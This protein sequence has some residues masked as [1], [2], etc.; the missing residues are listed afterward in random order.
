MKKKSAAL[1]LR[2]NKEWDG[3][4]LSPPPPFNLPVLASKHPPKSSALCP[5]PP[6]KQPHR[7]LL[8][9][10]LQGRLQLQ[11]STEV[12]SPVPLSTAEAAAS[13]P[14]RTIPARPPATA[15][16]VVPASHV[17][18]QPP[19]SVS[20]ASPSVLQAAIAREVVISLSDCPCSSHRLPFL[21]LH[22]AAAPSHPS[23]HPLLKLSGRKWNLRLGFFEFSY[24]VCLFD[25]SSSGNN[26]D[27]ALPNDSASV[28]SPEALP[29]APAPRPPLPQRNTKKVA[30]RGRAKRRAV[31]ELSEDDTPETATNAAEPS[32]GK[33]KPSRPR[34]WTWEHDA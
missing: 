25:I 20:P 33:R 10:S 5:C 9:P 18:A 26:G 17:V 11:A 34:S 31:E 7:L 16:I 24:F 21:K 6:P 32:D 13:S 23:Q 4:T 1:A 8:G 19:S 27:V 29:T 15:S 12:F 28:R 30:V 22:V 14:P 3:Q 2:W